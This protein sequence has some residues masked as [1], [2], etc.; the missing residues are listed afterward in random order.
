[1]AAAAVVDLRQ[2]TKP[3]PRNESITPFGGDFALLSTYVDF[4]ADKV[5]LFGPFPDENIYLLKLEVYWDTSQSGALVWDMSYGTLAGVATGDLISGSTAGRSAAGGDSLDL[6]MVGVD[7]SG[8]YIF[9]ETTTA[10]TTPAATTLSVNGIYANYL[11][12]YVD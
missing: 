3:M 7:I 1:M 9:I 4:A 12:H 2:T 10:G 6:G 11:K 8:D 5:V